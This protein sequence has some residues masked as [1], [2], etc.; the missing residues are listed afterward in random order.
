MIKRSLQFAVAVALVSEPA[1]A[2]KIPQLDPTWFASQLVWL[3]ASFFVLLLFVGFQIN[4]M[5]RRVL[6]T[7]D[8]AISSALKEAEDFKA[9]AEAAKSNFEA[10]GQDARSKASALIAETQASINTHATAEQAKLDKVL[11]GKVADAEKS[12]KAATEKALAAVTQ[13]AAS[14]VQTMAAKLLGKE[15]AADDAESAVKKVA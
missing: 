1:F 14:L 3:A 4:P 9:N 8:N 12:A 2:A 5:M 13:P 11:A 7:R 6:D 10:A 15:V